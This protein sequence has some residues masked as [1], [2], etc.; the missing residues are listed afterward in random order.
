[1]PHPRPRVAILAAALLLA[2]TP[3]TQAGV[4]ET[5]I[6]LNDFF[7]DPTVVV[8]TDG[9]S[10]VFT[11]DPNLTPLFL[12]N[13]PFLGDPVV[14]VGG[15]GISLH[16][17][18]AFVEGAPPDDD[19]FQARLFDSDTGD[20]IEVFEELTSATGSVVFDLSGLGATTLGLEL[21]LAADFGDGALG[22]TLTVS[23]LR[24]TATTSLPAPA[25]LALSL[26]LAAPL[27]ARMRRR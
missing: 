27:A 3:L 5:P 16:V 10:A 26:S 17:D 15:P 20:P 19:L 18:Y 8:A 24:L 12:V 21:V 13:D 2:A 9:S 7:A 6:D 14:I 4:I 25:S 11:E 1:M 23:N 22:S